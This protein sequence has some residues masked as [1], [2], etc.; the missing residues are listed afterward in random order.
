MATINI[1][2]DDLDLKVLSYDC[3][4]PQEWVDNCIA[5]LGESAPGAIL[6]KLKS[7][8]VKIAKDIVNAD[9]QEVTADLT[10]VEIPIGK[11]ITEFSEETL[12]AMVRNATFK[13]AKERTD[14]IT[15]KD[16]K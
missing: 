7:N 16:S 12:D 1:E 11:G 2:L 8:K 5:S 15:I 4:A 13:T 6:S 3:Y 9:K 14:E 10:S